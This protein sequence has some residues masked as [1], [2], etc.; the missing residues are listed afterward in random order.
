M[1]KFLILGFMLVAAYYAFN[2]KLDYATYWVC[3][4]TFLNVTDSRGDRFRD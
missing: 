3:L 1:V 4:A 2:E